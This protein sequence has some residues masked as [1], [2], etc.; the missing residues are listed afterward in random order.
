M[1]RQLLAA[2]VD[3][4]LTGAACTGHG[5]LFDLDHDGEDPDQREARHHQATT[6]CRGCPVHTACGTAARELGRRAEGVWAGQLRGEPK[7]NPGRPKAA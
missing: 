6:L 5:G 2:L 3:Q 4:R 1:R 7:K